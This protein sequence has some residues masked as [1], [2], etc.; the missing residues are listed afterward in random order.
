MLLF[1]FDNLSGNWRP[2]SIRNRDLGWK[3]SFWAIASNRK[4]DNFWVQKR[5]IKNMRLP[6]KNGFQYF[7]FLLFVWFLFEGELWLV[8]IQTHMAFLFFLCFVML[9]LYF[10]LDNWVIFCFHSSLFFNLG[11]AKMFSEWSQRYFIQYFPNRKK[12]KI[13]KSQ[14]LCSHRF[15]ATSLQVINR[16]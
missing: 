12:I 6:R 4:N 9:L 15:V 13:L 16:L 14:N 5:P 1:Y 3:T 7:F 2:D 10:F 8:C 11:L